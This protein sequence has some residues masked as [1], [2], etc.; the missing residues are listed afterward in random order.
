MLLGEHAVVYG[1]PCLVTAVSQRIEVSVECNSDKTTIE[2]TANN[3]RFV[4]AAIN[5]GNNVWG[6]K[7]KCYSIKIQQAFSSQFGFGSSSAVTVATL[8]A[9]AECL[10]KPVSKQELFEL[11]FAVV[12]EVQGVASGFDVAAAVFGNT[13][14]YSHTGKEIDPVSL[15]MNDV[16][17]VIG[18]SGVKADTTTLVRQ[19]EDFYRD[20]QQEGK[21]IFI[22]IEQLVKAGKEVIEKQQWQ[23]LGE[24]MTKNHQLLQQ[25]DVSTNR[26]DNLVHASIEAGAYGAKLSGAGGGDCMIAL[27]PHDRLAAVKQ[28]IDHSGG[29]VIEI[30]V[31]AQG[32][33]KA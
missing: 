30:P 6:G 24:L 12:K 19:V 20:H 9:L 17:L 4:D 5:K 7:D 28:A 31:D 14:W 2:T 13:L 15:N 22:E 27:T 1:Y 3:T 8:A 10:E 16:S 26:L 29:T 11:A 23:R 33:Y 25:L 21:R 32:V 18:Y